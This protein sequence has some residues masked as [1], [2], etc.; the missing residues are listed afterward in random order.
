MLCAES[1]VGCELQEGITGGSELGMLLEDTND[2]NKCNFNVSASAYRCVDIALLNA[3]S[4]LSLY[5]VIKITVYK[6]CNLFPLFWIIII[7]I[8]Q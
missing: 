3:I 1:V 4:A 7:I 6:D 2:V 8:Q 5:T